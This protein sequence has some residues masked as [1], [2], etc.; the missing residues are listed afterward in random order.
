MTAISPYYSEQQRDLDLCGRG[1]GGIT[2]RTTRHKTVFFKY[3]VTFFCYSSKLDNMNSMDRLR[4]D[5]TITM[6]W[7]A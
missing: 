6:I 1:S 7:S 2:V 4:F 3:I 5:I